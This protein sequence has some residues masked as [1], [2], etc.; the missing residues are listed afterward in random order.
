MSIM[1]TNYLLPHRYKIIGWV[2]LILGVISGLVFFNQDFESDMLKMDVFA[3]YN[4]EDI[5]NKDGGFFKIIDSIN[6][7]F[8]LPIGS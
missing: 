1:K 2:L 7:V 6:V 5:F 4:G 3:I 8:L